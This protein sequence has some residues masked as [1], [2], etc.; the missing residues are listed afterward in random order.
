MFKCVNLNNEKKLFLGAYWCC[1]NEIEEDLKI[2]VIIKHLVCALE[3][4]NPDTLG[5][6]LN[7]ALDL[8]VE[9]IEKEKKMP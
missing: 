6:K 8:F 1:H 4:Q 2:N 7:V 9:E 5:C 3:V